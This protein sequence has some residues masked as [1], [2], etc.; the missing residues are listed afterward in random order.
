MMAKR[1]TVGAARKQGAEVDEILLSIVHSA[2]DQHLGF[3]A[4]MA[5][6]SWVEDILDNG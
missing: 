1:P 2:A 3:P 5:A 4:M 6:L